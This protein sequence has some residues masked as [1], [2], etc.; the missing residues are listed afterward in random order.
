MV[1]FVVDLIEV[2]FILFE[3]SMLW[4]LTLLYDQSK[5]LLHDNIKIQV[6]SPSLTDCCE[7]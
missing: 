6:F 4:N 2:M 7:Q 5:L 1:T 3:R